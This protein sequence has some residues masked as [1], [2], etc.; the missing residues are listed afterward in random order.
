MPWAAISRPS[1]QLGL[2]SA[3]GNAAGHQVETLHACLDFAQMA[4]DVIDE[5]RDSHDRLLE[6]IG[7]NDPYSLIA[8]GFGR[9]L[10]GEWAFSEAAFGPDDP[11]PGCRLV[12]D[13]QGA[14]EQS[15]IS[16]DV[17]LTL[18]R[19]VVPRFLD[20]LATSV[21]WSRYDVVG[22]SSTF[23]QNLASIAL[24]RRLKSARPELIT[25]FG[26]SNFD[27]VM[28]AELARSIPEI[29]I[30]IRGEA[31]ISFPMLLDTL[32]RG[33][34]VL[35]VPG[36]VA[37]DGT[38][39]HTGREP[40]MTLH[41]DELPIPE[42]AEFFER[43][44]R[45]GLIPSM[46]SHHV[47]LPF[48]SAR[49]CWWGAKRH[50]TFCGLNGSTMS[51]RSKSADRVITELDTLARRYGSVR[52]SA[53]DNIVDTAYLETVF[54]R[55]A[56]ME[57]SF[58]LFYEVKADLSRSD[59]ELMRTA[60]VTRIQAGIESLSSHVLALMRKGTRAAWNVNVL[61][62]SIHHGIA[63][64]WNMLW[65]FPGEK[66][67]DYDQQAQVIPSL[68]HLQPPGGMARIWLERFSP[69]FF[70]RDRLDIDELRPIDGYRY[71]YP[72]S[73]DLGLAAY[74][75]AY[76]SA[77][78][79][80][81]EV[82]IPLESAIEAWQARRRLDPP[83]SLLRY[84]YPTFIRIVDHRDLAR[85]GVHLL[86]GPAADLHEACM[87]RPRTVSSI[88]DELGADHRA[89][90]RALDGLV[91][92]GLAFRDRSLY[93]SLAIPARAGRERKLR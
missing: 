51:F 2:L 42:Y 28:G 60:G 64:A 35:D 16:A 7:S 41:M 56:A 88:A 76:D 26:G 40:M 14:F 11:D 49:G 13:Q 45:L 54:P 62:W 29:D 73:M 21:D 58:D 93:L 3:I 61:R 87:D 57:T 66:Q 69:L 33:A 31:D 70:D 75:F 50:C 79:V 65:G 80:A 44:D 67:E 38:R 23:Q 1:I 9:A 24:A 12:H 68:H 15:L 8:D 19:E 37:R 39:I 36:V 48:E 30:V 91:D 46:A 77:A 6:V 18:R 78:T 32:Q 92:Q 52:L 10:F 72:K 53:V 81:D 74:Y 5:G 43:A 22:F 89:V 47:D 17:A 25:L 85:P 27:S 83:P 82:L 90:R 59:L 63:V 86:E 71:V 4:L 34:D 55:L 20:H 84:K